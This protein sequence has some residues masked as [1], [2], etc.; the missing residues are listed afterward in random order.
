[1]R[2]NVWHTVVQAVCVFA[3][4]AGLY[5]LT[6]DWGWPAALLGGGLFIVSVVA[7]ASR[8]GER[9]QQKRRERV[10]RAKQTG[11]AQ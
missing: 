11:E 1:M 10:E 4:A 5:R 7:E 9:H 8:P 2:V 6:G 3:L